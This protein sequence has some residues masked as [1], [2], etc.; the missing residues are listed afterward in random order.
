[1]TEALARGGSEI[2]SIA[3]TGFEVSS[4][5]GPATREETVGFGFWVFLLSDIVAF[6]TFF[7]AFAVL[8]DATDGGPDARKLFD[9]QTVAW[10]TA[11]LLLSS[12]ACGLASLALTQRKTVAAIAGFAA[13]L[14]FGGLFLSLELG[15]F[16]RLLAQGA[17]PSRSAFLSAF[18]SLVGA[19]GL[20]VAA[21]LLWMMALVAQ[22]FTQGYR[23]RLDTRF[24]CFALFWHAL[25]L[26]WIGVFT[27]VYLMGMLR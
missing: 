2:N 11:F 21:G 24:F 16:S 17:S 15:E 14:V 12:F 20:H 13:L 26:V 19:H 8:R 9:L 7:A 22:L 6:A 25:D 27:I 1:M 5:A 23:D 18:F 4:G 3:E 10:E